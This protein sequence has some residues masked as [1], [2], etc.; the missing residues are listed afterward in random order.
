MGEDGHTASLFPHSTAL[1]AALDLRSAR[2]CVAVPAGRPAP[3]Q[4]RLSLTLRPI[5]EAR[6]VVLVIVGPAKLEAFA[7]A[8]GVQDVRQ[9]PVAAVLG[10]ARTPVEIAWAP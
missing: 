2:L 9:A 8:C 1:D 10:S 6:L 4:P 3:A 5:T 7:A